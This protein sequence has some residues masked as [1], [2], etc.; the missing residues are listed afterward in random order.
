MTARLTDGLVREHV[1]HIVDDLAVAELHVNRVNDPQLTRAFAALHQ[2]L[3]RGFVALATAAG[4]S[5][6]AIH[7]AGGGKPSTT[8]PTV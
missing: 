6:A 1:T 3:G 7:P 5:P 2:R 8:A 4:F